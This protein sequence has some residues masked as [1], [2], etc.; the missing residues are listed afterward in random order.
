MKTLDE[1][2]DGFDRVVNNMQDSLVCGESGQAALYNAIDNIKELLSD[3][4]CITYEDVSKI[5]GELGL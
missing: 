2:R 5:K 1:I 3:W 4:D